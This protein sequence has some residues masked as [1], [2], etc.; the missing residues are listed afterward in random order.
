MLSNPVFI[1][2][3]CSRSAPGGFWVRSTSLVGEGAS[4]IAF[5][6]LAGVSAPEDPEELF[7]MG[8]MFIYNAIIQVGECKIWLQATTFKV[9]L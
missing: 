4:D 6:G 5:A 1:C 3:G 9:L 8:Y 2:W 7:H